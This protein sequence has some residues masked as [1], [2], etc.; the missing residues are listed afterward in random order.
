[1]DTR[2]VSGACLAVPPA[3]AFVRASPNSLRQSLRMLLRASPPSAGLLRAAWR[4][5]PII[6]RGGPLPVPVTLFTNAYLTLRIR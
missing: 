4:R 5:E 6:T 1:M 3:T 2:G